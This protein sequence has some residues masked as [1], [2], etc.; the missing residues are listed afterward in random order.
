MRTDTVLALT[1]RLANGLR[2]EF[3][4]LDRYVLEDWQLVRC[5]FLQFFVLTLEIRL[6]V[7]QREDMLG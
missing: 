5:H 6:V 2:T 3:H 7:L 1:V 4:P